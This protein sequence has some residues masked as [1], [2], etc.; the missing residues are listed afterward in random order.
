MSEQVHQT[1][2]EDRYFIFQLGNELCGTPLLGVKE[3][4]QSQEIKPVPN[5][6]PYFVGMINIRGQIIGVIDLRL[7]YGHDATK[8]PSI[9]FVVF[10]TNRGTI[11]AIVD[12]VESV[13]SIPSNDID[14]TKSVMTEIASE[15]LL[16]IAHVNSRLVTILDLNKLLANEDI[17]DLP[18][19]FD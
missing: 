11:A 9:A 3:V 5:T 4:L 16:G 17:A 2:E 10:D 12:R 19:F 15:H 1:H 13:T 8:S 7:R 14:R 6:K 18:N